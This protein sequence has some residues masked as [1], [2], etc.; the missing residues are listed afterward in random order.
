MS[1]QQISHNT[2]TLYN[3][4]RHYSRLMLLPLPRRTST[5]EHDGAGSDLAAAG[6]VFS[7]TCIFIVLIPQM[8][9]QLF[10][11]TQAEQSKR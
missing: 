1:W 7:N 2:P 11:L 4:I 5:T 10:A 8:L 9:L 6:W 3:D